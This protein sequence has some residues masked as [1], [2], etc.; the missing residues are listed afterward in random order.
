MTATN[1]SHETDDA[2]LLLWIFWG[3]ILFAVAGETGLF[4]LSD[5]GAGTASAGPQTAP[6]QVIPTL[7]I[8]AVMAVGSITAFLK[9]LGGGGMTTALICWMLNKSIAITGLVAYQMAGTHLMLV[10]YAAVFVAMMAWMH[11]G[12]MER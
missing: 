5:L 10:P 7:G 6:M 4:L 3:G 1:P 8:A 2:A 9:E 11:P 12:Q